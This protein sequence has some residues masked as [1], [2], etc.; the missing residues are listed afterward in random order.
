MVDERIAGAARNIGGQVQEGV[1]KISGDA[2]T[3]AKNVLNQAVG[4]VQ[5]A[6]GQAQDVAAEG[7]AAV[8]DAAMESHDR[9]KDFVEENP[10]TAT[11]IAV[12]IGFLI[13][14]AAHRPPP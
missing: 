13:G 10:H 9:L 11:L 7:V 1:G 4:T 14:Y 6:Y 2:K 8:K 12:A 5:D 3:E